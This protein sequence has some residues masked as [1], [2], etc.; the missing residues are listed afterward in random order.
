MKSSYCTRHRILIASSLEVFRQLFS[1]CAEPAILY[2]SRNNFGLLRSPKIKPLE[3]ILKM[4]REQLLQYLK[5]SEISMQPSDSVKF[6]P[7]PNAT[8]VLFFH[9][10]QSKPYKTRVYLSRI[11]ET[12]L[13][14]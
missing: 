2:T 13:L 3:E 14:K 5:E 6:V 4:N 1:V 7:L 8:K 11:E 12:E 10:D 9:K